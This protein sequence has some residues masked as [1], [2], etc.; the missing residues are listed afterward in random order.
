MGLLELVKNY[1]KRKMV[2]IKLLKKKENI[3]ELLRRKVSKK[4]D[5][6]N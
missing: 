1:E 2:H 4:K 5:I 6:P 3:Y